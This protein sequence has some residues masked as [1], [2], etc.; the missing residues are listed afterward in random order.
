M[1][2]DGWRRGARHHRGSAASK[3][4]A[5]SFARCA[6]LAATTT[7]T[8]QATA[9]DFLAHALDATLALDALNA[10]H[11][12]RYVARKGAEVTRQTLYHA[13]AHLRAFLRYCFDRGLIPERL[14]EM[15]TPRTY[16]GEQSP[17]AMPWPLVLGLLRSVDR[18]HPVAWRDY[19]MLHLMA[20]YGLRPSEV[21][22][23]EVGAVD[24]E[25]RTLRVTRRKTSSEL[26]LPLGASTVRVLRDYLRLGRSE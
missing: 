24:L 17:R 4:T 6:G 16:R 5:G 23:L 10:A 12:E 25:A 14:D 7:P 13:V 3:S 8:H 1:R 18:S 11:V 19:A 15:D 2:G 26:L 22:G 20:Y 9:S 21:V